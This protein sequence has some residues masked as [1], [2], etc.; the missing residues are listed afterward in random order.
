MTNE[1]ITAYAFQAECNSLAQDIFDYG[2]DSMEDDETPE[3]YRDDMM[4]RVHETV[5]GHEWIIYHY[6]AH[7]ICAEC[8]TD[9]GEQFLEDCGMPETP[10]YDG[11]ASI[12]AFGE[13]RAR[14]EAAIDELIEAWDADEEVAA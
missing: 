2:L 6:R 12:I 8:D 11:L 7:Q 9:E 4:D 1:R 5:D 14:V 10:T 3:D 13:M